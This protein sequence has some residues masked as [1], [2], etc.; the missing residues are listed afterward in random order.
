MTENRMAWVGQSIER[1]EDARAADRARALHRRY[2]RCRPARCTPRCCARRIRM[3]TSAR[4]M[5]TAAR[6][7]AGRRGG[8]SPRADVTALGAP[9]LAGVKA[10]HPVLAD[11]GRARA[12]C[13]RAGRGRGRGRPLSRRGRART[14]RGRLRAAAGHVAARR[15]ARA[16]QRRCCTRRS[17][18]NVASDRSFRYGDP[19]AAFASRRASRLGDGQ[20]SAQLLHADR[21]LRAHRRLRSGRGRLRVL[22][23]FQGP[24]SI[25]AVM[26]RALKVPGN[27]LRL[28]MPPDAGGSFG[29]K[30]G[31]FPYIAL[32][33]DR[34]ARRRPA[35]EMDRGPARA[36]GRL[37]VGDQP[38]D[39]ARGR[40]RRPTAASP[41]CAWD[42]ME[43]V[44]AHIRAPE[45]A[46]LY[47][48]HGN[49]TGAYDIRQRVGAQP[50]GGDQQDA[51]RAQSRLRR[52]AGL[53]RAR[54][55]DAAHRGRARLDPLDVIR[56]NLM[57]AG[58]FPYRTA[59]GGLLNSGDYP[60]CVDAGGGAR[61]GS[62]SCARGRRRRAP[63]AGSTASAS[64]PWSSRASRTW[65]T[66]PP[67]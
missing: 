61:A 41:R 59:T 62:P 23:N 42:Q 10:Q 64:P 50:R 1:V 46:T 58:A 34:G 47:R 45:P 22:A 4:S 40:G 44:G 52:P 21:D 67:C 3:R 38:A 60:A 35:G 13:R 48:M 26:A 6:R 53:L 8:R 15:C 20:L 36:S 65:A 30:Q 55:A 51:D 57:P 63:K 19:E 17:A 56:R 31:I 28:R 27:R 37:G 11:R 66:S 14:D 2:R 12:L 5:S 24:F 32:M 43:D 9:L 7:R 18:R 33:G 29:V 39:H 49:L 16:R 54:A 25:H